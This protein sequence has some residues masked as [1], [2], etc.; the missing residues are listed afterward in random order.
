[1][2]PVVNIVALIIMCAYVSF[3]FEGINPLKT[4]FFMEGSYA[5]VAESET[6]F[7]KKLFRSKD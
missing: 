5:G 2:I 1:M 4:I 7:W 6:K 3:Y